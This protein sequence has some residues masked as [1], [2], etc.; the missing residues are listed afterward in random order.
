MIVTQSAISFHCWAYTYNHAYKDTDSLDR[1]IRCSVGIVQAFS[2]SFGASVFHVPGSCHVCYGTSK[3][4]FCLNRT[5]CRYPVS[6]NINSIRTFSF[7]PRCR[8]PDTLHLDHHVLHAV[9][10][11]WRICLHP[12]VLHR[13][14]S[15]RQPNVGPVTCGCHG[16]KVHCVFALQRIVL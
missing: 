7:R 13:L 2:D 6:L 16:F 3:Y 14:R 10:N 12:T 1:F 8:W 9:D 4:E 5:M 15:V 11:R